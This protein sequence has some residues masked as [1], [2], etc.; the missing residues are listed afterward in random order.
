MNKQSHVGLIV[1][2]H[3]PARIEQ[4]LNDYSARFYRDFHA[5]HPPAERP[6]S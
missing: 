3:D 1:R 6:T 4:L 5:V 2:S